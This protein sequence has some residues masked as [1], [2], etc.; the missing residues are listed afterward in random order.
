[1]TLKQIFYLIYVIA[2]AV[3]AVVAFVQTIIL[4]A[5]NKKTK[6]KGSS[7]KVSTKEQNVQLTEHAGWLEFLSTM[8]NKVI[9]YI[10]IAE[11]TFKGYKGIIDNYGDI[12]LNDVLNKIKQDCI[13]AGR[14]Y[15]EWYWKGFVERMI[16]FTNNVNEDTTNKEVKDDTKTVEEK[17]KS[18]LVR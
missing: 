13:S 9:E 7:G 5:K 3:M 17:F 14:T 8:A 2:I 15:D 12:K 10:E 1:M 18:E 4:F 11:K 16:S 6:V